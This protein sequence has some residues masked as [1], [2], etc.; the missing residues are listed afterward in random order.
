MA[1]RTILVDIDTQF[2]FMDPTGALYVPGAE[3]LY[4][5]QSAL[6]AVAAERGIPHLATMDTHTPD[7]PEFTQYSFPPHCVRGTA[8]W[9]KVDATRQTAPFPVKA[10][11]PEVLAHRELLFQ[12]NT[13]D[14][15]SNP[16]FG[17]AV[18]RLAPAEAVVFG[19][20]TDYCVKAAVLGLL[21][22]GVPVVVVEDAIAAVTAETGEAAIAE[23][24]AAGA[25]FERAEAVMRR[26]GVAHVA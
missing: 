4:G 21:A 1:T 18:A 2:D 6:R 14:A 25:R 12:K 17:A 20:A 16:A 10:D 7:D 22:A 5:V 3:R 13:F 8:G 19:V 11:G 23:M 24:K 9:A 26:L 15:F